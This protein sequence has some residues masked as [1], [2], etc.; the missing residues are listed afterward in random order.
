MDDQVLLP[1]NIEEIPP[2]GLALVEELDKLLLVQLRDG[3]KIIGT[4]RSFDQFANLVLQGA[5]ER[6]IV[7]SQYAEIPLGL[8]VVRG[9]NVVLLGELDL[10]R[11]PPAG[12]ELVSEAA[13]KQAQRAEREADKMKGTLRAR[14]D[15]L[16]DV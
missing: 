16:D 1:P 11:E 2:P 15:F 5:K 9:E 7:G 8:H 6:I 14:F 3:R 12:L 10:A 4:L 13:I